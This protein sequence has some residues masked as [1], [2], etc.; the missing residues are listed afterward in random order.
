MGREGKVDLKIDYIT[1]QGNKLLLTITSEAQAKS[2]HD[3]LSLITWLGAGQAA[4]LEP[5]DDI[6]Q[7]L[8]AKY[9]NVTDVSVAYLGKQ[10]GH[11]I[12]VPATCGSQMKGA[13][14]AHRSVQETCRPRY[15]QDVSGWRAARQSADR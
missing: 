5:V 3:V 14:R 9:G 2:G 11:W 12:A 6:V 4:N 1:S 8:I 7:P 10:N 15:H 13:V